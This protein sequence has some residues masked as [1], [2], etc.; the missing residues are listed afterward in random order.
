MADTQRTRQ[1][2]EPSGAAGPE[3]NAEPDGTLVSMRASAERILDIADNAFE[4]IRSGDSRD[5]L[6]R[7]RQRGGQ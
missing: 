3:N 6:R 2:A 7:H 1:R 5:H 4:R